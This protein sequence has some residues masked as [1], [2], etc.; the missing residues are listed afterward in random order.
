[1]STVKL[2]HDI[3]QQGYL[4][5]FS[6]DFDGMIT[7]TVLHEQFK[8]PAKYIRHS[9]LGF[10]DCKPEKLESDVNAELQE[11]LDEIKSG[12]VQKDGLAD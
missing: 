4:V 5:H 12:N 10:P 8:A 2:L 9:H 3:T 6:D 7:M 1:M 11:L